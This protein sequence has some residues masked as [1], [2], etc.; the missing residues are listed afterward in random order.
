MENLNLLN[1]MMLLA[2]TLNY[3][4]SYKKELIDELESMIAQE[5]NNLY[6]NSKNYNRKTNEFE[7]DYDSA[8]FSLLDREAYEMYSKIQS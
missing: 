3:S 7:P 2:Q 5:E 8:G 6:Y 4:N 1:A